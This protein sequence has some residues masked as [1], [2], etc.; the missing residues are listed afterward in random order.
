MTSQYT[1]ARSNDFFSF[2]C[3]KTTGGEPIDTTVNGLYRQRVQ[4]IF[5]AVTIDSDTLDCEF[6]IPFDNNTE[7]N[8]AELT[9]YNLSYNTT[10]QLRIGGGVMVKAGYGEDLG[11][12]FTGTISDKQVV[13][14]DT[15][16]IITIKAMDGAGL[17]KCDV[18]VSY[19]EGN[20]AQGI[21]YDLAVR[22]GFPIATWQPV[23]DY[24]FDRT[25]NVDGSL[26]DAI[27]KYAGIC[28]I[29]AYVCKGM[30]YMQPLS[31]AGL[32]ACSL[33]V[34]TGLLTA[35]EYEKDKKNGEFEDTIRGWQ[36]E[37]LLNHRIQTGTR[38]DLQSNRATGSFYVQEGTHEYD[39]KTM[40]TKVIAVEG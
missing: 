28:G 25:N 6:T 20:T 5:D 29:S 37:M 2:V 8:E 40:T 12:I 11:V 32:D 1:P 31:A 34:E 18:E 14:A 38:I 39:G 27:E 23:R 16:R 9:I 17:R 33:S 30:L 13:N 3:N 35:E 10:N 15:D 7:A 36:L 24:T 26:M 22:L 19:C 21:L 4:M